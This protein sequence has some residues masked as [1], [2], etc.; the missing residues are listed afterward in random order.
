MKLFITL[1]YSL[2]FIFTSLFST[3]FEYYDDWHGNPYV[4]WFYE[5]DPDASAVARCNGRAGTTKNYDNLS[6]IGIVNAP[7]GSIDPNFTVVDGLKR[8]TYIETVTFSHFDSR[9]IDFCTFSVTNNIDYIGSVFAPTCEEPSIYQDGFC[10]TP[11]IL[12]PDGFNSIGS[13]SGSEGLTEC[14]SIITTIVSN[15]GLQDDYSC[16]VCSVS[17]AP[18]NVSLNQ[19]ALAP[20][21]TCPDNQ[22]W[23]GTLLKCV[24]GDNNETDS[25]SPDGDHD[26]DG[27]PNRCDLQFSDVN[28]MD[29][30]QDGEPNG[31][32]S[33][34]IDPN[35]SGSCSPLDLTNDRLYLLDTEHSQCYLYS[36]TLN[37]YLNYKT[38]VFNS[39][40]YD[41]CR[42][43]CVVTYKYCNENLAPVHGRCMIPNP[44]KDECSV[45][46]ECSTSEIGVT[47]Q[48]GNS[49]FKCT[50]RCWCIDSPQKERNSDT[51][52]M[53]S[54]VSCADDQ[55]YEDEDQMG[56]D[57]K[58][59]ESS[60]FEYDY[61]ATDPL[62]NP[63]H[64]NT[65][66]YDAAS[67]F[68]AALDSYRGA[69]EETLKKVGKELEEQSEQQK[70]QTQLQDEILTKLEHIHDTEQFSR[71]EANNNANNINSSLQSM[72]NSNA[73]ETTQ[74]EVLNK[75]D[76]ILNAL[77][78]MDVN[79]SLDINVSVPGTGEDGEDNNTVTGED[80]ETDP[81]TGEDG[82]NNETDQN[83]WGEDEFKNS[84]IG[85][86]GQSYNIFNVDCG[87]P[88]FDPAITFM[89]YVTIE[90]PLPIM[91]QN[92]EQYF[93]I[94][95]TIV[96]LSAT[97]AG[98]LSIFRK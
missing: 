49:I 22:T 47:G 66:D 82:E 79:L 42:N 19:K 94:I 37:N 55:H 6:S 14:N 3:E 59:D 61:N 56:N 5:Q 71:N 65:V 83:G 72:L 27:I 17:G 60:D 1:L 48:D 53:E 30:D 31:T 98:F 67:S 95:K 68:K 45:E 64:N 28:S 96:I 32:D 78:A 77:D 33:D 51:L 75:L 52:I 29:C 38:Y 89:D 50:R 15:G 41:T 81:G 84:V 86:Y 58:D 8:T 16:G 87:A 24:S 36:D 11:C 13:F 4:M 73:K 63:D 76:E 80:N 26:G 34:P 93:N 40:Q 91:H 46:P 18:D 57:E 92:T 43:Q 21:P 39:A 44:N 35:S 2:L 88:V 7:E 70:K 69:K 90:N 85:Q 62:D 12:V 54:E 97:L 10:V 23:D 74:Q 9:G 20:Q 25:S